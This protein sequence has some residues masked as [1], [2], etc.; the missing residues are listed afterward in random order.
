VFAPLSTRTASAGGGFDDDGYN[1]QAGLFNGPADGV[2]G[3]LDGM[4]WGDPTYANDHLNMK[5][6]KGWP[7][8]D[9]CWTTNHWNGQVKDGSGEVWHYKIKRVRAA[10]LPPVADL[11][12]YPDGSV[13]IWGDCAVTFSHGT[14]GNQHFWDVHAAHPGLGNN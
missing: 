14:V 12:P 7:N 8:G 13:S 3:V 5:S 6:S 9:G 11:T 1:D 4:V 2:D 10:S